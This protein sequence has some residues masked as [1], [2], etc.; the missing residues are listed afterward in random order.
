MLNDRSDRTLRLEVRCARKL[1]TR[2]LASAI[3]LLLAANGVM[4]SVAQQPAS[5][6]QLP[7]SAGSQQDT[8]PDSPTPAAGDHQALNQNQPSAAPQQPTEEP[9]AVGT[10]AAPYVKPAGVAASRP[11][12]AAIAPAK[13]KRSHAFVIKF[14]LIAGAAAA[15][16]AI[17]ALSAGSRSRP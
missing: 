6:Q 3:A 7:V 14:A 10:A 16:G 1:A 13:Q 5:G 2:L 12:G 17:Y 9:K 15:G 4:I 8:I 11:A